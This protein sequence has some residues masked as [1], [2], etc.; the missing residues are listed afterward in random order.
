MA[1]TFA[2]EL[3]AGVTSYC[4][5]QDVKMVLLGVAQD[6]DNDTLEGWVSQTEVDRFIRFYFETTRLDLEGMARRD[7]GYHEDVQVAVDGLGTEVLDLGFYGFWPLES[8]DAMSISGE[9]CDLSE[10]TFNSD[11]TLKPSD[12]WGGFPVFRR[13]HLNIELTLTYGYSTPPDDIKVAQAELVACKILPLI[14]ASNAGDLAG[15]G[16]YQ[17]VQFGEVSVTH[18]QQGRYAPF[19]RELKEHVAQV[20]SRYTRPTMAIGRPM[21]PASSTAITLS[22]FDE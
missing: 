18:Y 9:D 3:D 19:L 7:F 14:T 13:G 1:I 20:A 16:G 15:L 8:I 2:R 12:Y 17:R 6:A 11:G 21:T 10:Y 5:V 4:D 22:K